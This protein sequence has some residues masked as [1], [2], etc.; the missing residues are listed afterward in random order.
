MIPDRRVLAESG[1]T[2]LVCDGPGGVVPP[3]ATGADR[4]L[5]VLFD[6]DAEGWRR[7]WRRETSW[8]PEREAYVDVH[9]VARGSAGT[10]VEGGSDGPTAAPDGLQSDPQPTVP[11]IPDTRVTCDGDVALTT[12]SRPVRAA[13]ILGPARSYVDGWGAEGYAPVV[14]VDSLSGLLGDDDV[15]GAID[16]LETLSE[17]VSAADATLYAYCDPEEFE[18]SSFQRLRASFD[19]VVGAGEAQAVDDLQAT[20]DRFRCEEPTKYG[21]LRQHWRE[22][23]RGIETCGRNYPQARQIHAS[24]EE[25][26]TTPRTLGAALGALVE[27]DV[28]DRWGETVSATRYN[29]TTYDGERLEAI[30][31]ILEDE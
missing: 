13:E 23:K 2:T 3:T 20:I 4:A 6:H 28:I 15:D 8:A 29:L 19:A 21:Y 5:A 30:G 24:L 7:R 16:A 1:T 10:A 9:D 22:A 25:P 18:D 27:F 12:L 26:T 31:R 17:S 11:S 14:F